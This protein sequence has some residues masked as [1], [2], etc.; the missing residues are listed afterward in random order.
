MNFDN[1]HLVEPLLKAVTACGYEEPTPIQRE[2]IP[3]VLAGRDVLGCAQT[4]TGKTAAFALPILQRLYTERKQQT[5][6][7]A[8]RALVLTPTRELAMQIYE[9]FQEYGKGMQLRSCVIF[10]G[11]AQRPQT[12]NLRRGV[13]ILVATP[14]RLCDLINQGYIALNQLEVF[15]LDEADRML[16]MG[17]ITDVRK[18][19]AL[20]PEKR[21]TLLFSA[22]MPFEVETLALTILNNPATVKVDP[23]SSTV[24]TIDQSLYMVDKMNKKNLLADILQQPE[25]KSALVFTRTKHGAD[26]V[27]RDLSREGINSMAIHGDKSQAARQQALADFKRGKIHVLVATDIAA[28]GIDIAG[29]SHVINFDLPNEP[30]AYVH[31]IG[32]TGRAGMEGIALSFCCIDEM[33]DLRGIEKLVGRKIPRLTSKWPMGVFTETV[34]QPRQ[35]RAPRMAAGEVQRTYSKPMRSSNSFGDRKPSR[36]AQPRTRTQ[37]SGYQTDR[38]GMGQARPQRAPRANAVQG[39]G[40][41]RDRNAVPSSAPR[42]T[43]TSMP[44]ATAMKATPLER[45]TR[46]SSVR[47]S[48]SFDGSS[49]SSYGASHSST[50]SAASGSTHSK[51]YE[52]NGAKQRTY[53]GD[54]PASESYGHKRRYPRRP[55]A[56]GEDRI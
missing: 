49:R 20:L 55:L 40:Y 41:Q 26:R 56:T 50:H 8:I 29:L 45:P 1:L 4:G 18:V 34:K 25:V 15:V 28:R 11:V 39:S 19:I 44:Q 54:K 14:G 10:G 16:D 47:K 32:R 30:E 3:P 51:S 37:G 9:N 53:Q 24:D 2:T 12:E 23:V 5:G 6:K 22:T 36:P 35:P 17:F 38:D 52:S 13:D 33:K 48:S 42:A 21:Q 7:R 31:R 43:R 27:V 46:T